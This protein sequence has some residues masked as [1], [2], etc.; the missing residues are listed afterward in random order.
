MW[1]RL[2][3]MMRGLFRRSRV[4]HD[5]GDEVRFHL[6][7]R[8]EHWQRTGLSRAEAERRARL[9]FGGVESFKDACREARGLRPLDELGADVRFAARLMRRSPGFTLVAVSTLAIAIGANT[10]IYGLIDAALLDTLPVSRPESLRT[11]EWSSPRFGAWYNGESHGG[12]GGVE[13]RTSFSYPAYTEI[14]DR[15]RS[16]EDVVAFAGFNEVNY[17]VNGRAQLGSGLL[18][19]G[20]FFSGLGVGMA[21]GRGLVQTDDRADAPP[22]VVL[23]HGFWQ[24]AFAGDPAVIGR[25]LGVN[26]APATIVG[27]AA[28][29]FCGVRPGR[30][31]DVIAPIATLHAAMYGEPEILTSARHWGF[32]VLVRLRPGVT[33]AQATAEVQG[34]MGQFILANPP[35]ETPYDMPRISL[36]AGARGLDDLRRTL[37]KPLNVLMAVVGAVLLIACANI[38]GILLTQAAAR[39]HEL[40]TRLALGAGRARLVRQLLTESVMLAMVGGAVGI[41]V[42]FA[43]RGVLPYALAQGGRPLAVSVTPNWR[44]LLFSAG[45]CA[46]AGVLCGV[47]PAIAASKVAYVPAARGT[48]AAD[49]GRRRLW[50][51]KALVVVQ[52]A[53]SLVLVCAAGLF[54]RTLVNLRSEALGFRPDHLLLFQMDATLAGYTDERIKDF[55]ES[56]LARV[57]ATAGVRSASMSRWGLISDSAT[58]DR[59]Y[60]ARAGDR[61]VRIHY[62]APGYFQTMGIALLSG[63]D[64]ATSDR[65][66]APKV[67]IV[68]QSLAREFFGDSVIGSRFGFGSREQASEIEVVGIAADARFSTLREPAPP[69]VY[70]P[71]RQNHQHVMTFAV[72]TDLDP[73]TLVAPLRQ[74]LEALDANVPISE[75]RTQ[76]TQIERSIGQERFFARLVSGFALVALVLAGLGIYGT[77]AYSVARRTPEIG[78]R[79]AL[80]AERRD[81]VR[82]VVK[83]V[84]TPILAGVTIGLAGAQAL[85]QVLGS[86][87]FGLQPRDVL[88]LVV[89]ATVLLLCA[90]LATWLPSRRASRVDPMAALREE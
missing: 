43:L 31:M 87:L 62:V 60:V 12:E 72:R 71:Y 49:T 70:I 15:A 42:A 80:G 37:S 69:T 47:L 38:T 56:A 61:A 67:A 6:N 82:M 46:L 11:L 33:D 10:A 32:P 8:T 68:N 14:R 79:M 26:G 64:V 89:A 16:L 41:A 34:L 5:L 13:V 63:R 75:V 35:R 30:C 22:A 86:L 7:A 78:L 27:I 20:N 85:A 74:T 40:S 25:T 58:G 66:G 50:T 84:A 17:S 57:A 18:V 1:A 51:G 48:P 90:A 73:T 29:G 21:A 23:S 9:E 2:S 19:S 55:Y 65:D 83:E 59:I 53:L 54:V 3:S 39:R 77:L 28:E 45:V 44:M 24:R 88:S 36:S 76:E 4:E 81:V 52:V